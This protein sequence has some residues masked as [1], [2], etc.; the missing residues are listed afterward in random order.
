[1]ARKGEIACYQQF[2]LFSTCF[3]QLDI[4]SASKEALCGKGL[5]TILRDRGIHARWRLQAE[6]GHVTHLCVRVSASLSSGKPL[7][8]N[9]K[10]T[11]P[12]FI[13]A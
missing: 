8:L 5:N 9:L 2:L 3:P 11:I 10:H 4:F 12:C 7:I 13:V 6:L 1:M